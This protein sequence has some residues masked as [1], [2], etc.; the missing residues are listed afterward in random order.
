MPS[1]R[2][3]L[4]D[5]LRCKLKTPPSSPAKPLLV[6]RE[7]EYATLES[8]IASFAPPTKRSKAGWPHKSPSPQ[9]LAKAGFYYK[10]NKGKDN[11]EC[12]CC[13]RQLD[14]WEEDDDALVEHLKHGSDCA[15]AVLMSIEQEGAYDTSNMEDPTSGRV[16]E[17]R[18]STFEIMAWPHEGKR[19]WTCKTDKMVE[20]GWHFAPNTE[21]EDYTSCVYCRLSLDG[22]EPKDDP[23]E[24][25]HRRSPD[26]PFFVFAGTTASSKRPKAKKGRASKASR[27]SRASRLSAQSNTTSMSQ[28]DESTGNIE[29]LG[30][31]TSLEESIMDNSIVSVQ[32]TTSTTRGKR[33]APA[34]AKGGI[35][36]KAKTTKGRKKQ[37]ESQEQE[38][39]LE[40]QETQDTQQVEEVVSEKPKPKKTRGKK[41]QPTPEPEP[42][43]EPELE[44]EAEEEVEIVPEP[45]IVEEEPQPKHEISRG[46]KPHRISTPESENF[47]I[48]GADTPSI[49]D[50]VTEQPQ[51]EE[52][53][54][55]SYPDLPQE[56][57]TGSFQDAAEEAQ[58]EDEATPQATPAQA[59]TG[60]PEK[61]TTPIPAKTISP[62]KEVSNP[63]R[64]TISPAQA[65]DQQSKRRSSRRS[66]AS[67]RISKAT[68]PEKT[69]GAFPE[70]RS[71]S[72]QPSDLENRPPSSLPKESR[73]P[74]SS[75]GA[76]PPQWMPVDIE[77]ILQTDQGTDADLFGHAVDGTLSEAEKDM[78]V[79][80]WVEYV[81]GQAEAKLSA[82]GE[83]IVSVFEQEGRRAMG[84]LEAIECI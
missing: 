16:E 71:P 74:L 79:Q 57:P 58:P 2:S 9:D 3:K 22:W 55:P 23:F 53:Q 14:G 20:A 42:E 51:Q 8:R 6:D 31:D 32:S 75:P 60:P 59:Q 81:A 68:S 36:K 27:S 34:R 43:S 41:K 82:E 30:V 28:L 48:L 38:T 66:A 72:Q 83:R 78:T 46:K 50:L 10:P 67:Q 26:C 33:K 84:V 39:E 65:D 44:P 61:E 25:H 7:M 52:E 80:Q 21:C 29:V 62:L 40:A 24:E 18:R 17:A 37:I 19:G 64:P 12:F 73:P 13:G 54:E 70:S 77:K 63:P 1:K 69:P 11:V 76:V 45:E 49:H 15:W 5:Y 4:N 47:K 35:A 56:T